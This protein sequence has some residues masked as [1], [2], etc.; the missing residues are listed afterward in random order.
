M[1]AFYSRYLGTFPSLTSPF[2][3]KLLKLDF[4]EY[5]YWQIY[6]VTGEIYKFL[7]QI[8]GNMATNLE[9]RDRSDSLG[10]QSRKTEVPVALEMILSMNNP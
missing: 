5:V 1:S 4:Y 10:W 9:P 8:L 2:F 7:K 6:C 3:I